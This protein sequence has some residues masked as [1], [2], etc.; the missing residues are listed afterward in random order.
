MNTIASRS[1]VIER[2]LPHPPE[3]VWRAL[4]QGAL[5]REWMMDN[6]F[7]PRV[8]HRFQFRS[9]PVPGWNGIIDSEVLRIE[10]HHTLAYSWGSMGLKNTVTWTLTPTTGGTR[11]RMEQDGFPADQDAAYKGATYGWQRFIGRLEKVV[12]EH[13]GAG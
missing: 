9:T 10:P 7:E 13:A 4:T 2:E 6:D 8:G 1:L 11:L 12:A 5:I 3:R